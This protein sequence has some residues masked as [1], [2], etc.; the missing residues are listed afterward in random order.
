[1]KNP[2]PHP[3]G[4]SRWRK[5]LSTLLWKYWKKFPA[6]V[7]CRSR[8]KCTQ[9]FQVTRYCMKSGAN[10]TGGRVYS[11]VHLCWQYIQLRTVSGSMSRFC[12]FF[13]TF[14]WYSTGIYFEYLQ[15]NLWC[16][17]YFSGR[18]IFKII[19][20]QSRTFWKYIHS[21]HNIKSQYNLLQIPHLKAGN[22]C[23]DY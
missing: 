18:S 1:M 11:Y 8:G 19:T 20:Q 4:H 12:D 14:S 2:L 22:N 10:H 21:T 23:K 16:G 13:L 9:L 7:Q 5:R 6:P 15:L 3:K 17:H